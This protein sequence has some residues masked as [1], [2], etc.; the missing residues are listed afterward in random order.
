VTSPEV[1][2]P[3]VTGNDFIG[4]D[5]SVR[6]II[7]H[8][9]FLTRFLPRFFLRKHL[10]VYSET[11]GSFQEWAC[12]WINGKPCATCRT[13]ST[14]CLPESK[15]KG[16]PWLANWKGDCGISLVD[17]STGKME[18]PMG[19]SQKFPS[20]P[21]GVSEEK[22]AKYKILLCTDICSSCLQTCD[23]YTPVVYHVESG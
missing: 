10:G 9:F 21:R 12:I 19:N 17:I 3:E 23:L 2:S 13:S 5:V 4:S 15:K 6:E 18:C 22:N 11:F 16:K 1:A 20:R 7:F 14:I 8:T